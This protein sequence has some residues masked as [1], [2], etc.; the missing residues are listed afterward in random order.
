MVRYADLTNAFRETTLADKSGVSEFSMA[1]LKS[2]SE[3]YPNSIDSADSY[4]AKSLVAGATL[5]GC[6]F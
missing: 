6:A 3:S 4:S 2:D 5:D 1:I